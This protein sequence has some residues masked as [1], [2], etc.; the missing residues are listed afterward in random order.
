MCCCFYGA[1]Y[2]VLASLGSGV[3][4]WAP[5]IPFRF[6]LVTI[7]ELAL[8]S[9][10]WSNSSQLVGPNCAF[11]I[12]LR[13][14]ELNKLGRR[15]QTFI[16]VLSNGKDDC[17]SGGASVATPF[18]FLRPYV[19]PTCVHAFKCALKVGI[20]PPT[21]STCSACDANREITVHSVLHLRFLLRLP[22]KHLP[23]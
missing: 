1:E 23:A 5:I 4:F 14:G 17:R 3:I 2:V 12:H 13:S 22:S 19:S 9:R 11:L 18:P 21:S 15:S 20:K 10:D 7:Q 6:V 8:A 16:F